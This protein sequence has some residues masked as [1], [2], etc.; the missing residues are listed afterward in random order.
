MEF[1]YFV[2]KVM[3]NG[4][5]L[6]GIVTT[7]VGVNEEEI[8]NLDDIYVLCMGAS[9]NMTDTIMVLKYNPR[10]E[11]AQLLSIPRDTFVGSS[12]EN[13]STSDKINSKYVINPQLT[14]NAVNELTGLNIK[15]YITVD[16]KAL[17]DLVDCIGGVWFDVPMDMDY[18][19]C[20]QDLEIHL[21]QGYQL[22]NGVQAEGVVRF[23]HNN[24]GSSF[25]TEYG[26]NDLGRMRTQRTFIQEVIKQTMKASNITKINQLI[27]IAT[28]EVETN[29]PWDVLKKYIAALMY[30]DTA[31]LESDMLPGTPQ[32]LNELSFVV[33]N[34]TDAK[35]KVQEL[36]FTTRETITNSEDGENTSNETIESEANAVENTTTNTTK[37]V[38]SYTQVSQTKAANS[39]ISL[40]VLNAS[41]STTKFNKAITQLKDQGYKI[42]KKGNANA[43]T[44]T[45]IIN[46]TNKEKDIE[47][48][49]KSLLCT[50]ITSIGEDNN[51]VDFTIIIG[52]DY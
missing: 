14:I 24:D 33:V 25:S 8:K 12:K 4:G 16:T 36:F 45:V 44:R 15:Y 41:S 32:Y 21:K 20:T 11:Q 40:E 27:G 23:R 5:G 42:S 43:S 38:S 6:R 19:D 13:A 30:F 47:N 1:G 48:A 17:R 52:M 46:R 28:E 18:D 10:D 7:V 3:Q 31:N 29:I 49:I 35:A 51:D 22:L 26:D 9:Q 50:G 2:V 34:P 37:K 39:E